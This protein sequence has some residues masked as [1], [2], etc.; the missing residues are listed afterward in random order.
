MN[1]GLA[2][3]S[4]CVTLVCYLLFALVFLDVLTLTK[5][6]ITDLN[7]LSKRVLFKARG[8]VEPSPRLKVVGI[9]ENSIA[10]FTDIGVY[11]P[12]P[13][14]WHGLALRRLAD[15]G[16]KVV[17]LDILFAEADSWDVSEDEEL[18][19]AIIY[20][21]GQGCVVILACAI[22]RNDYAKRVYSESLMLP[23]PIILEANAPL[24]LSNALEKLS[25]KFVDFVDYKFPAI[26]QADAVY[27]SQAVQALQAVCSQDGRDFEELLAQGTITNTDYK[28][29]QSQRFFHINY[30]APPEEFLGHVY[31]YE[32]LFP[33]E[34]NGGPKGA[35]PEDDRARLQRV[36]QGSVV[37]IGSRNRLDN[38]YFNTPFGLMF[39]VD[40]NAQA[41]DTLDRGRVIR[42]ITPSEVLA[43]VFCL[44]LLAWWLALQRP[45][46]LSTAKAIVVVVGLFFINTY[47]FR[48]AAIDL[49]I[50][51]TQIGFS[52]P[53]IV[54]MI[55]GGVSEEFAKRKIRETFS[56]YVSP[57]IVTQIIEQPG[58]ADLGG[59]ERKVAV[60]FCD[61]RSYSTITE[62]LAPAEIVGML[63]IFL[64]EMTNIIRNHRGFVDKYM[65][66]GL[67][68][69]F[70]GPVPTED[71][72][73]DAITAAIEMIQALHTTVAKKL[74]EG[75]YPKFKAGV[76]IHYGDV[77]MGNIGSEHRMDY[78]VIGDAV[79]VAAR[80]ESQTKE[81]GWAVLVTQE[82]LAAAQGDFAEVFI[83]ERQVKG[84]EQPVRMFR[85]TD[86][87]NENMFKY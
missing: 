6:L 62:S 80:V 39:G 12:F 73:G 46:L 1:R 77:V 25:F 67:M 59:A 86:P 5:G 28:T 29:G 69:C 82:A 60:M 70:G 84:R 20:A 26:D 23:A 75:G 63:N 66:D 50:V 87:L 78:T 58:L 16:A 33:A 10:A 81:C 4:L 65:G 56:K 31:S 71:P 44:M 8:P 76:G 21:Q 45:I 35:L 11:Y 14:D 27:Y 22:E 13:R 37:F 41:F 57:E 49:S 2:W 64:G 52:F 47:L 53:F 40:T 9:T 61:I 38:D 7:T 24:G 85:V 54:C 15:S 55:Y 74:A 30:F 36:F 79:N 18:R 42:M 19:D 3:K 68:A 17:V 34:L 72:A 51:G 43:L 32:L 83:G 48:V